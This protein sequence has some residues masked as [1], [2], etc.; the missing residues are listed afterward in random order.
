MRWKLEGTED[1]MLF[2]FLEVSNNETFHLLMKLETA[3]GYLG[4][5]KSASK[6]LKRNS[7]RIIFR[8]LFITLNVP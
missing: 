4:L 6:Y 7:W 1:G 8:F 2:S 5:L 3:D